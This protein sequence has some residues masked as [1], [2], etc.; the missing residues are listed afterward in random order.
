MAKSLVVVE[1]PAKARTINKYLGANYLVKSCAGHIRDLPMAGGARKKKNELPEVPP[2]GEKYVR[3]I[4]SM[5][6]NPYKDW[7]AQYQ[8]LPGKTKITQELQSLAESVDTI[9][10]ATDMDRE[11]EAIA[12]HLTYVLGNKKE[13]KRVTFAEITERAINESFAHPQT[14]N[15]NRVHAQQARRFLDRVVGYMLS[16]L[17]WKKIARGLSA[18]RVQ[19]VAVKLVVEREHEIRQFVP[20]EYWTLD[21]EVETARQERFI[22]Q[23]T[24]HKGKKFKPLNK[25]EMDE[26]LTHLNNT[27]AT[28]TKVEKK[29]QLSRPA[30]PFITSTLQQA[31]S[32]Q[33]G[34]SV[35]RTMIAAQRL[36]EAGHITYMRTDSF[37]LSSLSLTQV[38]DYIKSHY[39]NSY[40]PSQA[41]FYKAKAKRSQEAHEAIRPTDV[42]RSADALPSSLGNTERKIYNLIWRRFVACQM[43]DAI[44]DTVKVIARQSDYEL[45]ANGRTLKFDGWTKVIAGGGKEKADL[46]DMKEKEDLKL[47]K[48]LP[49]QNFTKPPRR[50]TEASLV[51]EL[52]SL[53]IGRPSTYAPTLSTIQDRGYV[54]ME[55][56]KFYAERIAEIVTSRLDES[57]PNI[58]EY[59]FTASIEDELDAVATGEQDWK[60][61]LDGF[62]QGFVQQLEKAEE[63]Q[64]GMRPNTPIVSGIQCPK[65]G[66][67]M[68]IRNSA[69]GMFLGCAGYMEKEKS[70][71]TT[72]NLSPLQLSED[73]EGEA[74]IDAINKRH[75]CPRCGFFMMPYLVDNHRCL[76]IC[77][78]N[79]DCEGVE[80]EEGDF[81]G[82]GG[83]EQETL[84]CDKCGSQMQLRSSRFGKYFACVSCENKRKVLKSGKVAPP[85][86]FPIQTDI[87]C[88]KYPDEK[89]LLREGALGLFL[90]APGFPKQRETRSPYIKEISAYRDQ[91]EDRFHFLTDA[92][93]MDD[94][95]NPTQ[96][97]YSRKLGQNYLSSVKD[98]KDTGW[99]AYHTANGWETQQERKK[100]N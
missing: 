69:Q 71:K 59:N 37:N 80:I 26:T 84:V 20:Q 42:N 31:S 25:K 30:P 12:W 38:R 77:G 66:R 98:G 2:S 10:L 97:R 4:R 49:E 52:E 74:F 32:S 1:S 29:E 45:Q 24:K 27:V 55:K 14:I 82:K 94:Q 35:R 75:Q 21:A 19:S 33:L 41:R 46:P 57:F 70:C 17:L 11:G 3:I 68:F 81:S 63:D 64:G 36:Y 62:Y 88:A 83:V 23:V 91:L 9:Y 61:M 89:Y 6:I 13:Y 96:I 95:G 44:Y 58:L 18:G 93:Q 54:R 5:G 67:D 90:C 100:K 56:G 65:C 60:Q 99:R 78:R 87:P 92:P 22:M 40:L 53:G 50:W 15:L 51:K 34:Y 72:I 76:H 43:S 47:V 79:P 39:G 8:I 28:I 73:E 85:R 48:L 7:E 16:P 86:M